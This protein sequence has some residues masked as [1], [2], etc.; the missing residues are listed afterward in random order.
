M[1]GPRRAP[2]TKFTLSADEWAQDKFREK[3]EEVKVESRAVGGGRMT[4]GR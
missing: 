1:M 3:L 2:S 4:V